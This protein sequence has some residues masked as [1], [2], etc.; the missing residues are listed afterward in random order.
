MQYTYVH[1]LVQ[2]MNCNNVL[3]SLL[4]DGNNACNI[5][6]LDIVIVLGT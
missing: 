2:C 1:L 4:S 6:L 5:L 3:F